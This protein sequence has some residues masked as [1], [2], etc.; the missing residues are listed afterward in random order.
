MLIDYQ[1]SRQIKRMLFDERHTLASTELSHDHAV[2][3][4]SPA[5]S[6]QH[7]RV[8][9]PN[10]FVVGAAKAGTSSLATILA[11][12]PDVYVSPIKEPHFFCD[13]IR[14]ADFRAEYRKS[15]SFNVAKYLQKRPLPHKHIAYIEDAPSYLDLFREVKGEKALGEL[16]TGYLYS[17]TAAENL[18][19]FNPNAK[20]VMIL[21]QPVER[22]YS[23][24][25]MNL[26]EWLDLEAPFI[27]ALERDFAARVKGWGISQL[28][29]E[30]GLYSDQ[31]SRYLRLFPESQIKIFLY[32]DFKND[33]VGF[34]KELCTFLEIAPFAMSARYVSELENAAA[35]PKYHI[36]A[37][38]LP[39]LNAL[40]RNVGAILPDEAKKWIKNLVL[41]K[42]RVP[43]LRNE[44]FERALTYFSEDIGKLSAL[45]KR[46]LQSWYRPSN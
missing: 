13:D 46:D 15:S 36:S 35:V 32:E 26:R 1:K 30:L 22:A 37:A 6:R 45:I 39:I 42:D 17:S 43:K 34:I 41:S 4:G 2:Q 24:Y 16:S 9:L 10:F 3:D 31:V 20:I 40:K 11:A 28:Y 25:L 33:P 18:F 21:R 44:E 12:H 7:E 27:H 5:T 38:Y 29:V 14:L 8:N 23:H 19:K